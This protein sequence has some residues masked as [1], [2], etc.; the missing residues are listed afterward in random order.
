[1]NS[2]LATR[3]PRRA[4]AA[5]GTDHLRIAFRI[6]CCR[7][8]ARRN[9]KRV[10]DDAGGYQDRVRRTK[11]RCS[12]RSSRPI[13]EGEYSDKHEVRWRRGG[14]L[15]MQHLSRLPVG[16]CIS[17][18]FALVVARYR[19][20]TAEV[21]SPSP[22]RWR[23]IG[24]LPGLSYSP[25]ALAEQDRCDVYLVDQSSTHRFRHILSILP[26]RTVS[27][28]DCSNGVCAAGES[29]SPTQGRPSTGISASSNTFGGRHSAA[30]RR[31][32]RLGSQHQSQF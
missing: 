19:T 3:R 12:N 11:R 25:D 22:T 17:P 6:R 9:L 31:D 16:Y 4:V 13:D 15:R 18:V 29:G 5:S 27:A 8:G 14:E 1:V 2:L 21:G 20:F 23:R 7:A 10:S 28:L 32:A 24:S 26:L 30:D